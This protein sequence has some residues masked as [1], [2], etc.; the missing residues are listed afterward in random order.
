M[1]NK[2]Y[3]SYKNKYNKEYGYE[4]EQSHNLKQISKDTGVSMKGLQQIY[5]KGI[6]AYKTNPSSVRPSVKSKEQWAM[7]RVYSS[8]MGGKASKIDANELKMVKGG[9]VKNSVTQKE[10]LEY[11]IDV[12]LEMDIANQNLIDYLKLKGVSNI[13]LLPTEIKNDLKYKQLFTKFNVAKGKASSKVNVKLSSSADRMVRMG[14]IQEY[15]KILANEI[16]KQDKMAK[17]GGVGNFKIVAFKEDLD[18]KYYVVDEI[19]N[20]YLTVAEDKFDK[21]KNADKLDRAFFYS[22]LIPKSEMVEIDKMENGGGVGEGKFYVIM[23]DGTK[24][25]YDVKRVEDVPNVYFAIG[26]VGNAPQSKQGEVLVHRENAL[27]PLYK[28]NG[29]RVKPMPEYAD[30]EVSELKKYANGGGVGNFPAKGEL[31]NKENY[32]VKY[33]KIG[34]QYEFYVY[35]PITKSVSAYEQKKYVCVNQNCPLKMSYNQ[36]INYLYAETYLD[37]LE[38]AEGGVVSSKINLLHTNTKTYEDLSKIKGQVVND[39]PKSKS[40]PEIDIQ[41]VDSLNFEGKGKKIN[42]SKDAYIIFND[43]WDKDKM[44]VHEEMNVLFVNKA[45][46]VIGYY[47]HSKGGIDGTV[48]DVEM[49]SSLAVKSLAKGVI[50]AH[51]HP[52][53]NLTPSNADIQVSKE[54]K[55]A[56]KLFKISLLDSIIITKDN[57]KSLADESLF[58][59]GGRVGNIEDFSIA[60]FEDFYDEDERENEENEKGAILL[61]A[62]EYGRKTLDQNL[63]PKLLANKELSDI[64]FIHLSKYK[65]F[66]LYKLGWRI[67]FGLSKDWVGLCSVKEY[68][69]MGVGKESKNRNIYLSSQF[70]KYDRN[71]KTNIKETVHHEMAHAVVR[72]LFYFSDDTF[73]V[74]SRFLE[75]D[76]LNDQTEG[77]GKI[78]EMI[79]NTILEGGGCSRYAKGL[80]LEVQ[81]KD[82]KYECFNCGTKRFGNR[83]NFA[84]KCISCGKSVLIQKNKY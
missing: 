60:R 80:D 69:K 6:G 79:C 68:E 47:K 33:E 22:E 83:S 5:N 9:G 44:L 81:F 29:S 77:H 67:Q 42:N 12:S 1:A 10:Y 13:G 18:Y 48:A 50:V 14:A 30:K 27:K 24:E 54:L 7:A 16:E 52:S 53:G 72:E 37:D 70:H 41:I 40:V 76:P 31:V 71:W 78:W 63:L 8:V 43:L 82:W 59:I 11:L 2:G 61:E 32:L 3:F 21:W 46:N 49:I 36:F 39:L 38:Y 35:Q 28:K 25:W 15:K 62:I 4:K 34:N 23:D 26:N 57:Y 84:T 19:E 65:E 66:N 20:N 17:G 64:I 45:N 58:D 74:W 56:L 75:I 51:N 73:R 55:D